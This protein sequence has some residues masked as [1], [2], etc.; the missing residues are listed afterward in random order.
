MIDEPP[1]PSGRDVYAAKFAEHRGRE[2]AWLDLTASPKV[3]SIEILLGGAA[4]TS[5]L[6][7]G[8]GA[9]SVIGG[10]LNRGIGE[11]HFLVDYSPT[12]VAAASVRFPSVATAVADVID[13]PDPFGAGPYDVVV[14]CHVLEHLEH[15]ELLL[16]ALHHIPHGV[17]IAEVPLDDLVA[18]RVKNLVRDRT[19]NSAGHVQ[20]FTARRFNKLLRDCGFQVD[21]SHRYAPV[22]DPGALRLATEGHRPLRRLLT[23]VTQRTLPMAVAPIWSRLYHAHYAVRLPSSLSRG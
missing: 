5:I 4:P 13:T 17:V 22:L 23:G 15:P 21:A 9:G 8:G 11:R 1:A 18:A 6:E 10:L 3:D 19:Q 16:S 20:F 12:A 14:V 2:I 7:I